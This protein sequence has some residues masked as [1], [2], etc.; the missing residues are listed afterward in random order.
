L[1]DPVVRVTKGERRYVVGCFRF[2]GPGI[3]A[4]KTGIHASNAARQLSFIQALR[5][6]GA[7]HFDFP[8]AGAAEKPFFIRG[9]GGISR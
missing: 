5:Q 6:P 2:A 3:V 8:A 7:Q 4:L 9:C 1:S